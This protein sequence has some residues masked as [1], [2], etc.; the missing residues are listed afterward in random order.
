[1]ELQLD[2]YKIVAKSSKEHKKLFD[3]IASNKTLDSLELE[4]PDSIKEFV[5]TFLDCWHMANSSNFAH[6]FEF[7]INRTGYLNYLLQLGE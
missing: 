3:I 1:M 7:I 5:K 4:E 6:S 2:F